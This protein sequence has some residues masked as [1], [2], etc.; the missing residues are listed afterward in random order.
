MSSVAHLPVLSLA[1]F[2]YGYAV[3]R[4]NDVRAKGDLAEV[5]MDLRRY[6][7]LMLSVIIASMTRCSASGFNMT[8]FSF[9]AR[10][11]AY[12]YLCDHMWVLRPVAPVYV[13]GYSVDWWAPCASCCPCAIP[14]APWLFKLSWEPFL[15]EHEPGIEFCQ[16]S[17]SMPATR[18]PPRMMCSGKRASSDEERVEA[19]V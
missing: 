14:A 8:M 17:T 12:M 4:I 7:D 5:P 15:D 16:L 18:S 3:I 10:R 19:T 9:L 2:E 11:P 13:S 6:G 1:V